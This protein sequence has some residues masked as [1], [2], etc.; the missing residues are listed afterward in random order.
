M[1]C[2]KPSSPYIALLLIVLCVSLIEL[3]KRQ[4]KIISMQEKTITKLSA[5]VNPIELKAIKN[6]NHE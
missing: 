4:T 3:P 1:N 5:K 2:T 6:L